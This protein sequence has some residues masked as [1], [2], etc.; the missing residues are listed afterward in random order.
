[1]AS[2]AYNIHHLAFYRNSAN[3]AFSTLAE[4]VCTSP[5]L[6][7]PPAPRRGDSSLIC[8]DLSH[9]CLPLH[10]L[11]APQRKDPIWRPQSLAHRGPGEIAVLACPR[12]FS[13]ASELLAGPFRLWALGGSSRAADC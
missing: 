11:K 1:M 7:P 8:A 5:R 13:P 4:P 3:P 6:F 10:T 2:K 9:V 12:L